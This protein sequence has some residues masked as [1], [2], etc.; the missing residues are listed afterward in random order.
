MFFLKRLF[1]LDG[2]RH[3]FW[4]SSH[5]FAKTNTELNTIV[6]IEN[7]HMYNRLSF[8]RPSVMGA[9]TTCCQA[10]DNGSAFSK[11]SSRSLGA[12]MQGGLAPAGG[13]AP[14]GLQLQVPRPAPLVQMPSSTQQR[15]SLVHVSAQLAP[16][17][18]LSQGTQ[19]LS[20]RLQSGQVI[21]TGN[22]GLGHLPASTNIN[23]CPNQAGP[24]VAPFLT[25]QQARPS[26]N[27]L[28]S[29]Q[30]QG[31]HRAGHAGQVAQSEV[32]VFNVNKGVPSDQRLNQEPGMQWCREVEEE[33][34]R[35]F[36]LKQGSQ[37]SSRS[38]DPH[39]KPSQ[40]RGTSQSSLTGSDWRSESAQSQKSG[41]GG[42]LKT[43]DPEGPHH[44]RPSDDRPGQAS[45]TSQ[46]SVRGVLPV[47]GHL[48]RDQATSVSG[49]V[50]A[51]GDVDQQQGG[52]QG[53]QHQG[54][55]QSGHHQGVGAGQTMGG[56]ES[57]GTEKYIGDDSTR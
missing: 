19:L 18:H 45:S 27:V 40:G 1:L 48:R 33:E 34:E 7:V 30:T 25:Q 41:G 51:G 46:S 36:R 52:G 29:T 9:S 10:P 17:G 15:P 50:Q 23:N 31:H 42:K 26:E 55:T 39:G 12:V 56:E 32:D 5:L 57:R 49:L 35:I 13:P 28:L 4:D 11:V 37:Q 38:N 8:V 24:L 54:A 43:F 53:G 47:P 3:T 20:N 6:H 44:G 14:P 16:A 21:Q 22:P 2:A